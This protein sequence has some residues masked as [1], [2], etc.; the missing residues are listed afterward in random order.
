MEASRE[1]R[2]ED[3][4]DRTF[5]FA[6]RIVKFCQRLSKRPE[7]N[8]RIVTQLLGAGTS[9]GA[10]CEEAGAADSRKHFIAVRAI[11]LRECRETLYWLRLLV[12]AGLVDSSL[13]ADLVD[14]AAQL[15]K[16]LASANVTAKRRPAQAN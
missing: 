9:V 11:V 14:E 4:R 8:R 16:I 13:V 15:V 1:H 10:N 7:V 2:P 12:A 5:R 6:V 3:I